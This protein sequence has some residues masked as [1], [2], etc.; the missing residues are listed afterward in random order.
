MSCRNEPSNPHTGA[1]ANT[2]CDSTLECCPMDSKP[3]GRAKVLAGEVIELTWESGI[4]AAYKN[5]PISKFHWRKGV[6]VNDGDGSQKAAVY[7]FGNKKGSTK[8]KLKVKITDSQ[9]V[10]G[11][12]RL[13]AQIGNHKIEGSCPTSVGE[14]TITANI[15]S[16][17]NKVSWLKDDISW[18]LESDSYG[19]S[20]T[21]SNK[22]R[23]EVFV[24]YDK[25]ARFYN[26]KG[27][28]IEV[29][30][31]LCED[32][33]VIGD[34][35]DAKSAEKITKHCHSNLGFK[36]DTSNGMPSYSDIDNGSFQLSMYLSLSFVSGLANTLF[37][38]S[39]SVNCHDQ[40]CAVQSLTGALGIYTKYC[41]LGQPGSP[42]KMIFGYIKLTKLVG[43][44]E[45]CNN[46]FYMS[47]DKNGNFD[48]S[49]DPFTFFSKR[50]YFGNHG[51]IKFNNKI[52]D[53]CAGPHIGDED[54]DDYLYK[55]IDAITTMKDGKVPG[56][57]YGIIYDTYDV[58]QIA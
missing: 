37:P 52:F 14:Y 42:H 9:N 56:S 23:V 35:E 55:S 16:L 30:R 48:Y 24:I 51:F 31:F 39:L 28:W 20:I 38:F 49:N 17:P 34:T 47:K 10:S 32:V 12:A 11:D 3:K 27:V 26:R 13:Y 41:L 43:V 15:I 44:D 29:L 45:L 46:P 25:P 21:L 7:L 18:K 33:L 57:S 19:G 50:S 53:A 40:A 22:T 5:K 4:K 1:S 58:K 8:V 54:P 36:Y 6:D 2:P